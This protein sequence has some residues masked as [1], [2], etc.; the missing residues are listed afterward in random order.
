MSNREKA[1]AHFA[2]TGHSIKRKGYL[3]RADHCEIP[4]LC[5]LSKTSEEWQWGGKTIDNA[6]NAGLELWGGE[7]PKDG[8]WVAPAHRSRRE[9]ESDSDFAY[10]VESDKAQW[11][12]LI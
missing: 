6:I 11:I 2:A 5:A 12:P 7:K 3:L 4:Y 10:T 1:A 9:V 8:F